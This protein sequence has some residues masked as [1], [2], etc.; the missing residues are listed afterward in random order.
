MQLRDCMITAESQEHLFLKFG[1]LESLFEAHEQI[2]PSAIVRENLD[3]LQLIVKR[4]KPARPA[5]V[6]DHGREWKEKDMK[7]VDE[8]VKS[9]HSL[10]VL[11]GIEEEG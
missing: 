6:Y 9:I 11:Q 7:G 4:I 10:R 1:S 3:N 8:F 2:D 5:G